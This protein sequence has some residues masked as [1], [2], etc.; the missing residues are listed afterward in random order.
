IDEKYIGRFEEIKKEFPSYI[1]YKGSVNYVDS[2]DVLKKYFALLFPTQF[3]TEGI[4][5]TIIDAYAAGLPVIASEWD[6]AHEIIDQGSTG[7]IYEFMRNS[8]LEE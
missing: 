1:R 7:Y 4:P 2:V 5:G 6:S 3:K 8:K